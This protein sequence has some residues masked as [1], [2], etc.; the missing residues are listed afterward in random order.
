MGVSIKNGKVL[1]AGEVLLANCRITENAWER[2]RGLLGHPGLANGEAMW[3][4]PCTSVHTFFMSFPIDVAFLDRAG[5]VVAL[6]H[7][8]PAWR[9]T[10]IHWRAVSALECGA[11]SLAAAGVQKG[12]VLELCLS[13]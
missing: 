5:K 8:L 4:R 11:G 7:S 3:F 12:Q 13:S 6:Y 9:H 2:M 10:L 1:R